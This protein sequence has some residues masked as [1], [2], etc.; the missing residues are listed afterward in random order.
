[1][2]RDTSKLLIWA[3]ILKACEGIV[4]F[5]AVLCCG[6]RHEMPTAE[7]SSEEIKQFLE[8]AIASITIQGC[9]VCHSAPEG[10]AI[11]GTSPA[12]RLP[13]LSPVARHYSTVKAAQMPVHHPNSEDNA[14]WMIARCTTCLSDRLCNG[15]GRFWCEDHYKNVDTYPSAQHV[16]LRECGGTVGQEMGLKVHLGLCTDFCLINEMYDA[17]GGG[18]WG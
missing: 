9:E 10:L 1:M 5:D 14:P 17:G 6:P 7:A 12:Y 4:A 16:K 13:L 2:L 15:C 18:M 3:P 8:P 11:P